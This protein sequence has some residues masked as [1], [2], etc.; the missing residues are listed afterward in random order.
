MFMLLAGSLALLL[1][2]ICLSTMRNICLCN[3]SSTTR[4]SGRGRGSGSRGRS[5]ENI[6][7]LGLFTQ[8]KKALQ[9]HFRTIRVTRITGAIFCRT[10]TGHYNLYYVFFFTFFVK[11]VELKICRKHP[12]DSALNL[13]NFI[14]NA[15]A[16]SILFT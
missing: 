13:I 8:K 11:P 2:W 6:I 3:R 7:F 15:I 4:G 16:N 14:L 9:I 10:A 5:V 12:R 1:F